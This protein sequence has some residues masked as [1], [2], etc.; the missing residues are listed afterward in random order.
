MSKK[1][2]WDNYGT[3][4]EPIVPEERNKRQAGIIQSLIGRLIKNSSKIL[5]LGTGDGLIRKRLEELNKKK[6]IGM[7]REIR[8]AKY[9]KNLVVGNI[10]S[11][12]FKDNSFDLIIL[13]GVYQYIKSK[14][15]SIKE[16][17]RVLNK[18]GY[19]FIATP[20]KHAIKEG[21]YMLYFLSW[22]PRGLA[23]I[24]LRIFR[25]I[26]KYYVY[27]ETYSK[28]NSRLSRFFRVTDLS[29]KAYSNDNSLKS[30]FLKTIPFWIYAWIL[31]PFNPNI[32]L[33]CRKR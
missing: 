22:L 1:N 4:I 26:K 7:D 9:K 27:Q 20:L 32:K 2:K 5:D 13:N 29:L 10:E 8:T 11:I 14:D 15:K 18:D 6:I 30:R 28:L 3:F 21:N 19:L 33:L 24:Y 31:R 25:G 16:I 12:P 17:S 23:N